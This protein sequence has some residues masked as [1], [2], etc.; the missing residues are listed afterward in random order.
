MH[1]LSSD[2]GSPTF[3]YVF[4]PVLVFLNISE[5]FL[6]L[7]F[8]SA[9]FA[10]NSKTSRI[11][12]PASFAEYLNIVNSATIFCAK[13]IM[14][15]IESFLI[16]EFIAFPLFFHVAVLD[17]LHPPYPALRCCALIPDGILRTQL[18]AAVPSSLTASSAP[19]SPLLC[20]HACRHPPHPALRCCALIPV[21]ILRAQLSAAVPSSL[22][23]SSAPSS[24][25]LCPHPCR[26]PPR[27]ALRCCALIPVGILRTQLS[28]AVP[29]CLSASS[30]PSSPLLCPHA[31]WHP[32]Y[33]ALRCCALM[34]VGI[35]RTQLSAAVPSC[36]SASRSPL[37]V[38]HA[39]ILHIFFLICIF[40]SNTA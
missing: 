13:Y 31:C 20:P 4:Y 10:V 34:P 11:S 40:L 32:P 7:C 14:L 9:N 38:R 3:S 8:Y 16:F 12:N 18:S 17:S 29:S 23:A 28:A 37:V 30:A 39:L 35:L 6:V 25:L 21:G 26:H 19:S 33:P 15:Q 2:P 24:P 27:P 22:T 5:F 1:R 36:P